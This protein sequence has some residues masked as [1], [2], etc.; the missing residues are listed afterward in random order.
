MSTAKQER[1]RRMVPA[2]G[3]S[4]SVLFL[5]LWAMSRIWCFGYST[6]DQ[7]WKDG[8]LKK[9]ALYVR[10]GYE[11]LT[12][13][14]FTVV[15]PCAEPSGPAPNPGWTFFR[16][17]SAGRDYTPPGYVD[18]NPSPPW[19]SFLPV[20]GGSDSF[21]MAPG[22]RVYDWGCV[23]RLWFLFLLCTIPTA[24]LWWRGRRQ[25]REGHC[26]KCGYNLTGNVSG[27]CPECGT[28]I[29]ADAKAGAG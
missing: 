28:A 22:N 9:N 11:G 7:Q 29:D 23:I 3:F 19:Q 4:L 13:G 25:R 8:Q 2:A 10:I 21:T 16:H 12:V 26:A 18:L 27:V 24:V 1:N 5:V 20:V 14:S 6:G 15:G 17:P